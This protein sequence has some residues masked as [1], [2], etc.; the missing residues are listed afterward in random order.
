M[1][2]QEIPTINEDVEQII[3][4][5]YDNEPIQGINATIQIGETTTLPAGSQATVRNSGTPTHAKLDFG[6]P[7]G[8]KGEH[9]EDRHRIGKAQGYSLTEVLRRNRRLAV[10]LELSE[11]I[12]KGHGDAYGDEDRTSGKEDHVLMLVDEL[13]GKSESEYRDRSV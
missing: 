10:G 13:L 3:P 8:E 12:G 2:E 1:Q 9:H 11:R 7:E 5:E 4:V 6:I